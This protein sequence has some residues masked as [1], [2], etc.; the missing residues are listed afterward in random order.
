MCHTVWRC[1]AM[2]TLRIGMGPGCYA[3]GPDSIQT[4]F[5]SAVCCD[6]DVKLSK[7][8][9]GDRNKHGNGTDLLKSLIALACSHKMQIRKHQLHTL[10][11]IAIEMNTLGIE[12]RVSRMLSGCDST[13]PCARKGAK[14]VRATVPLLQTLMSMNGVMS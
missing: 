8:N 9:A 3:K 11:P 14:L 7:L 5:W 10:D 2:S 12:P 4:R 13:T 1:I 6:A